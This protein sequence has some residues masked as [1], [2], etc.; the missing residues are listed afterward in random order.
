MHCL[1]MLCLRTMRNEQE[2]HMN[3]LKNCSKM[4]YLLWFYKVEVHNCLEGSQSTL[5]PILN[6]WDTQVT[7]SY[8]CHM[9]NEITNFWADVIYNTISTSCIITF[10][11]LTLQPSLYSILANHREDTLL[12]DISKFSVHRPKKKRKEKQD[13]V[14]RS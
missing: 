13:W 3:N 1:R 4:I 12:I 6:N 8:I 11:I 10:C 7:Q 5:P 2:H 14:I 9:N